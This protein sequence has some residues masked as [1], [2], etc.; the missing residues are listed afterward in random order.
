[1][2]CKA[3]ACGQQALTGVDEAIYVFFLERRTRLANS[4][5]AHGVWIGGCR[6][7]NFDM[8]PCINSIG[9]I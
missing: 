8:S 4:H 6:I 2:A 9:S 1:M 5:R 7:G 3:V